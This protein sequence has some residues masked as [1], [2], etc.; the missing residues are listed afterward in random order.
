MNFNDKT[1]LINSQTVISTCIT[2]PERKSSFTKKTAHE[3]N[4]S[5]IY[6]EVLRQL[7]IALP[8]L[9]TPNRMILSP[10]VYRNDN[11]QRWINKDTAFVSTNENVNISN[12]SLLIK[13]LYNCGTHNGNSNYHFT[14][15]ES[16]VTNAVFLS[17]K[18]EPKLDIKIKKINQITLYIYILL[19][20]LILLIFILYKYKYI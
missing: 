18:L 17:N 15:M 11:I 7:R 16:A 20:I 8:D 10:Q 13:N 5:E 9:P 4:L 19:I 14:S 6:T 12:H 1:E 2:F 3:S